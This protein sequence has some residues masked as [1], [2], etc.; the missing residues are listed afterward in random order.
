MEDLTIEHEVSQSIDSVIQEHQT[1]T[2]VYHPAGTRLRH[3]D[4]HSELGNMQIWVHM[5]DLNVR[6]QAAAICMCLKGTAQ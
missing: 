4:I 3:T 6:Q 5:T 2:T 1:T